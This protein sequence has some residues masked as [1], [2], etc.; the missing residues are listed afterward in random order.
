MAET[1]K[2]IGDGSVIE[3][4]SYKS[5]NEIGDCNIL[6]VSENI[7]GNLQ[8]IDQHIAGKPILIV[9]DSPG[10]ATQGSVINFVE[11]GGRVK[12]ELNTSNAVSRGLVISGSLTSLAI[13]I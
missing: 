9:T 4:E 1:K 8:A 5:V 12:F 11:Q 7:V 6:F 13:V 10:M 3:V 2:Q